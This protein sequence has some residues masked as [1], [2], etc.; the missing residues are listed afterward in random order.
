M[1]FTGISIGT[2]FT[3]FVVPAMYLWLAHDHQP[4]ADELPAPHIVDTLTATRTAPSL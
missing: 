3:L 4:K 1:I 2:A